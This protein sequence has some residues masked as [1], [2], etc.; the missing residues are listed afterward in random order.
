[1][2]FFRLSYLNY[3]EITNNV[4]LSA[5]TQTNVHFPQLSYKPSKDRFQTGEKNSLYHLPLQQQPT[6]KLSLGKEIWEKKKTF[7]TYIK[8]WSPDLQKE[9][10]CR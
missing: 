2:A 10:S 8:D 5:L 6:H 7:K 3:P 4:F 9:F 1:M